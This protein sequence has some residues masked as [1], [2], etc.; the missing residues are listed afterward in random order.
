M[1]PPPAP[2][3]TVGM[4]SRGLWIRSW[5]VRK[6]ITRRVTQT[7]VQTA[8]RS[9][10]P[11]RSPRPSTGTAGGTGRFG[12]RRS[13]LAV[14]QSRAQAAIA[15]VPYWRKVYGGRPRARGRFS[16]GSA[17]VPQRPPCVKASH[18][19]WVSEPATAER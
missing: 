13:P 1:R 3:Q 16:H 19:T 6:R 2:K 14:N 4:M 17:S 9:R 11:H 5:K 12:S 8:I 10:A 7:A 15:E 18:T